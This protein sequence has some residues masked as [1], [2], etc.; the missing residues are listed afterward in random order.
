MTTAIGT[1]T[2]LMKTPPL[3]H[4]AQKCSF[5]N[6][7]CKKQGETLAIFFLGALPF[8][9]KLSMSKLLI[10]V[11]QFFAHNLLLL[12]LILL[13]SSALFVYL[14][15]LGFYSSLAILLATRRQI[16]IS[17]TPAS[18]IVCTIAQ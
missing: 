6:F 12:S 15:L 10:K 2:M 13:H 1:T 16:H 8:H 9:C 3:L 11:C 18:N 4:V 14:H 17:F 5:K 7:K